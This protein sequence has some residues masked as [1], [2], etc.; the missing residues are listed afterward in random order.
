MNAGTATRERRWSVLGEE[1]RHA[2]L[3]R[4]RDPGAAEIERAAEALRA[5]QAAGWLAVSEGTHYSEDGMNLLQV[6]ELNGLSVTWDEAV[7]ASHQHR[8]EGL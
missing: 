6:R 2:W 3:G 5:Q 1:G 4:A 7:E 8:S